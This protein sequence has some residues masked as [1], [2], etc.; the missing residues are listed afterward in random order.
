[1]VIIKK[2]AFRIIKGLKK[3]LMFLTAAI[4]VFLFFDKFLLIQAAETSLIEDVPENR[5]TTTQQKDTTCED[6]GRMIDESL[7]LISDKSDKVV[8][9]VVRRNKKEKKS[10]TERRISIIESFCEGR[11]LREKCLVT[12][13]K[14]VVGLGAT[15]IYVDGG[16]F[17]TIYYEKNEFSFCSRP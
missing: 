17:E 14:P 6:G 1:M 8:I 9:F 4:L 2:E 16:L 7:S 10:V 5:N 3:I 11:G 15:E 13:G 12:A